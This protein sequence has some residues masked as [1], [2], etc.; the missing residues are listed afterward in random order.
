MKEGKHVYCE[1]PLTHNI[2]E[3]REIN[4]VA[5]E[6]G[7]ATQMGNQLHSTDTIRQTVEYLRGGVIGTIREAHAWVSATRW[8]PFLTGLPEEST[9][10]PP[11]FN[12]DLW[13]GLQASTLIIKC[14]PR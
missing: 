12:W 5:R 11:G 10:V 14:I 9:P 8:L 6:A 1:K 7:V 2:W 13:L 3:A 4:R